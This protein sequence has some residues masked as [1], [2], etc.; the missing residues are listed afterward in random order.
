MYIEYLYQLI[1]NNHLIKLNISIIIG[2]NISP[3]ITIT[4]QVE[5]ISKSRKTNNLI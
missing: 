3:I 5:W 4:Q 2:M 1:L